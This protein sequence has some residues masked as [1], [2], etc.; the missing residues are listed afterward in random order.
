MNTDEAQNCRILL[1]FYN[2]A[3]NTSHN[4]HL[5]VANVSDMCD[6]ASE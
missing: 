1:L 2:K 3:F 6:L 5:P 4:W